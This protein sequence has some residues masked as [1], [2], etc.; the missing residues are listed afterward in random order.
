MSNL[1]TFDTQELMLRDRV[2]STLNGSLDL[3][4]VLEAARAPLLEFAQADSVALCLMRTTPSL[5]FRW[6]VPGHRLRV[7][8]EYLGLAGHDFVRA[9]IFAQPGVVLR[10]PEMLS[11]EEYEQNLLYQRSRELD[12]GLEHV[13]AV[14]LPIRPDFLCAVALYRTQRRPFS[15]QCAAALSSL[16][17]HLVNTLRNCNDVQAF[18]TGGHLL[19]EHY[20]NPDTAFLVVELPHREVMRSRHAAV[21]LERWFAPSE[22]HSSG[23]PLPLKEQ[24]DA[25]VRMNPDSRVEKDVW[26]SLRDDGYRR[27]RF[28]E[29]PASEGPRRWALL[30]NEIP[31]SIPLPTEMRR[32]LTRRQITVAMYLLR[33]W[34]IQQ[35]ADELRISILT[36]DT[37]WKN[38]RDRLCIDSRAD[39]LYQAARLNKPV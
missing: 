7:L 20:R 28:I 31:T 26:V 22:L 15:A 1:M 10:D 25:L 12:L 30:L 35:I 37:H 36:V 24:L 23:L 38:I 13:M 16:N 19:E 5:D 34:P 21:L 33:N 11:R 32:K 29:L 14:L 17:P 9:P 2:I 8:D 3:P 18:T 4:Q 6:H 27:V 39:L